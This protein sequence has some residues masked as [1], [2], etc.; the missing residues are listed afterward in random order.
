MFFLNAKT[1][2]CK[3]ATP[4]PLRVLSPKRERNWKREFEKQK[5][6]VFAFFLLVVNIRHL[7]LSGFA[8]TLCLSKAAIS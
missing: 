5:V 3:A 4:I 6:F 8:F 1:L 7:K 2:S